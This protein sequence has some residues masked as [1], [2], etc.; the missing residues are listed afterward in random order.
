MR[1]TEITDEVL[2]QYVP[3]VDRAVLERIPT[4][5]DYEFSRRFE[6][7]MKR[8]IRRERYGA[9]YHNGAYGKII[10]IGKK[11]AV[12]LLAAL[13]LGLVLTLSVEAFRNKFFQAIRSYDGIGKFWN[14]VYVDVE[15]SGT[16]GLKEPQYIPEGFV[17]IDSYEGKEIYSWEYEGPGGEYIYIENFRIWEGTMESRDSEYNEEETVVIQGVDA[18]LLTRYGEW[19]YRDLIW[20]EKD[21]RYTVSVS[22]DVPEEELIRIAEEMK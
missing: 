19:G 11:A 2:Y 16:F 7:K 22:L 5:S 13:I 20:Y 10:R 21:M 3:I 4:K 14:M 18:T 12:L 6:R 9:S 15:E 8:M 17:L 1:P